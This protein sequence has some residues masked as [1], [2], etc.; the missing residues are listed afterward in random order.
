M[1]VTPDVIVLIASSVYLESS[2]K[3][4]VQAAWFSPSLFYS[5]CCC[6]PASPLPVGNVLTIRKVS[7]YKPLNQANLFGPTGIATCEVGMPLHL[8]LL[9]PNLLSQSWVSQMIL[10]L[11][12][13]F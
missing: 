7:G 11:S 9:G 10:E 5:E 6:G 1:M 13:L 8:R 4:L 2:V 3:G 12:I